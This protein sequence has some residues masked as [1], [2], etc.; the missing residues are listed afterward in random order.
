MVNPNA[1]NVLL[2]DDDQAVLGMVSDALTHHGMRVHPFSEGAHA[3]RLL[4]DPQGPAFDLVLSDINMEGMD[5]F[6]VI[7]RVKSIKPDLPVVLMTGQASLEYAIRAMRMGAANLFQKPLTLRELVNSVFHLVGLHRELRMAE[8][9]L[10]GLVHETRRFCF[11]SDELDIPSTVAHLTDRLVPLGFASP[12]NVDVIAMAYHEALVNALEHGNLE[13]DSSMK[14]DLFTP[15]DDY[16]AMSQ[17]RLADPAFATR[18]IE[19]SLEATPERYEVVI[20][21]EGR[22]FDA[23][24]LGRVSDETLIR[25][26]GRGL[27]MIRM[28]MDEVSHNDKG[29]EIRMLLK[30]KSG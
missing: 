12:T 17:A 29:N 27:A 28:V 13:L 24:R 20:R 6:D 10:K 19:V 18:R 5:G 30:R 23:H 1:P 16:A 2:I 26:C 4:E 15:K 8:A 9:G 7:H 21:D 14:G 11:R 3:I 25:Q 22:G